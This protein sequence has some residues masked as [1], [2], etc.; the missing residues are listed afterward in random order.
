MV[1]ARRRISASDPLARA[2]ARMQSGKVSGALSI[3]TTHSKSTFKIILAYKGS[4]P[5]TGQVTVKY[6]R[7]MHDQRIAYFVNH[8]LFLKTEAAGLWKA[9]ACGRS[10]WPLLNTRD[11]N[12][13]EDKCTPA[14]PKAYL[15]ITIGMDDRIQPRLRKVWLKHLP[16]EK[17]GMEIEVYCKNDIEQAIRSHPGL[18]R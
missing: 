11:I 16:Q 18:S 2:V 4:T 13:P 12:K 14:L 1:T 6:S 8:I 10:Y 5:K 3:K 9:T 17:N 7:E 15:F